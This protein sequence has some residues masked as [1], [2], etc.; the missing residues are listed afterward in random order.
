MGPQPV[1][2]QIY[3]HKGLGKFQ[4]NALEEP[5]AFLIDKCTVIARDGTINQVV[6]GT[7]NTIAGNPKSVKGI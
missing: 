6:M 1:F 2:F 4:E 3:F 5:L 7:Y